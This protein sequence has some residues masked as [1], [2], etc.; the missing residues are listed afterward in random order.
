LE[1]SSGG[2]RVVMPCSVVKLYQRFSGPC[3]LHLHPKYEVIM[4]HNTTLHGVTNRKNSICIF[5]AMKIYNH[6]GTY[7]VQYLLF[8]CVEDA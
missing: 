7:S 8:P 4:E 3:F 2:L 5:I 1:H 6:V